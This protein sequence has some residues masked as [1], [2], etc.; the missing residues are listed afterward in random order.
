VLLS[1]T[2]SSAI[3]P[4]ERKGDT[5]G[6]LFDMRWRGGG[7][8]KTLE[9]FT[10]LKHAPGKSTGLGKSSR[11]GGREGHQTSAFSTLSPDFRKEEKENDQRK[12]KS[13]SRHHRRGRR[14]EVDSCQIL[15]RLPRESKKKSSQ[16]SLIFSVGERGLRRGRPL[17]SPERRLSPSP[18]PQKALKIR[19]CSSGR[20]RAYTYPSFQKGEVGTREGGLD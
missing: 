1:V 11:G 5:V 13:G 14:A 17:S 10:T 3:L 4:S 2:P 6:L 16:N 12:K 18:S 19:S 20:C 9:A 7:T 8:R 15:L